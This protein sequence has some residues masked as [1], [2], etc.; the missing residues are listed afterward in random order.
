MALARVYRLVNLEATERAAL[1]HGLRESRFDAIGLPCG[2]LFAGETRRPA[3]RSA[4]ESALVDL[5]RESSPSPAQALMAALVVLCDFCREHLDAET[6]H[7]TGHRL[8][9]IVR[10]LPE[11]ARPIAVH[12]A[13][14]RALPVE[15]GSAD[16]VL[17]SPPYI[18]VHNYHQ[19]Y[20]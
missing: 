17:T 13:D 6:I 18:N 10:A 7:K 15:S 8:E 5:W 4:L 11:S 3:D 9:R 19:K 1:L 2:P 16:L 14:A 20:R 12:H